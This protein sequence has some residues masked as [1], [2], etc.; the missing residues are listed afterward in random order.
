M[1]IFDKIYVISLTKKRPE[2]L[3]KFCE[4]YPEDL[5][6]IELF[7]AI[8]GD[9]V[10]LPEWWN[11][12]LKGSYGCY[13]SHL[14]ILRSIVKDNLNNTIIF[15]DDAIFCDKFVETLHICVNALPSDWNQFYL[16]GQHLKQPPKFNEHLLK[17]AN[18][19]RTHGYI[20]KNSD[21]AKI[22]LSNL[23][24]KD[25]WLKNFPKNKYHIDYGYGFM[26]KDIINAYS[27]LRFLIGQAANEYSDTGSQIAKQDRWW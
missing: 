14:A 27:P 24:N 3:Y 1:V 12:H 21:T 9:N 15:E 22:L 5:G 26:H 6:P 11:Q 23:E 10:C 2:K 13:S 8:D 7:D 17:G 16:G 18:I 4:R 20:V 19:N 25:F